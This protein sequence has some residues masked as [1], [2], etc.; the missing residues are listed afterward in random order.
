MC[1]AGRVTNT[2]G[3]W[4]SKINGETNK[5]EKQVF[6][7][8]VGEGI[9]ICWLIDVVCNAQPRGGAK[10]GGETLSSVRRSGQQQNRRAFLLHACVGRAAAVTN[11]PFL[12]TARDSGL[13]SFDVSLAVGSTFQGGA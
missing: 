8:G 10:K 9:S 2:I 4:H 1:T 12:W 11:Q 3:K 5:Q 6:G 13:F 7:G